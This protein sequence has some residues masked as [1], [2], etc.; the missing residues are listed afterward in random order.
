MNSFSELS[1]EKNSK[2]IFKY[3][4][5]DYFLIKLF[6]NLMKKKSLEIIKY[7]KNKKNR[8]NKYKY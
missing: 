2:D 1:E 7:N 5:S 3:L 6:N 8:M 4:K